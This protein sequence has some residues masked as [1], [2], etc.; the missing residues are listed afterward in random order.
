[1]VIGQGRQFY[2]GIKFAQKGWLHRIYWI[3]LQ[4]VL[5]EFSDIRFVDLN[6]G[7]SNI[8]TKLQQLISAQNATSFLLIFLYFVFLVYSIH[9][10]F[11]SETV[12]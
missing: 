3:Y 4:F 7:S 8:L 9:I 10:L 2:N 1:M 11:S 5:M 12:S 6:L